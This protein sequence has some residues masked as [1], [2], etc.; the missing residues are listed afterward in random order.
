ML[1]NTQPI[2]QLITSE[3]A[4]FTI[5]D[6]AIAELREKYM[7]LTIN[8]IDDKAGY[9]K[10]KA[11]RL[12]V[13]AKRIELEKKRKEIL[14]GALTYQR[15]VNKRA[16]EI[17]EPLEAI[18]GY[19]TDMEVKFDREVAWI[20][21][22]TARRERERVQNRVAALTHLEAKF[23]G[24]CYQIK[25]T[26]DNFFFECDQVWVTTSDD[27]TFDAEIKKITAAFHVE[28]KRRNR[29][30][31]EIAMSEARL[32]ELEK[33]HQRIQQ[34]VAEAER[35]I[36]T[37]VGFADDVLRLERPAQ[38]PDEVVNIHV[39]AVN[40][41]LAPSLHTCDG[42]GFTPYK[43]SNYCCDCAVL[44]LVE[45]ENLYPRELNELT[46]IIANKTKG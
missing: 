10:V 11:A 25:Y 36:K 22:E 21:Q 20:K 6:A 29:V 15:A 5:T 41:G 4:K 8:G 24:F 19:L 46:L 3:L 33:K 14:E 30:L 26:A 28:L 18:E 12:D 34:E 7:P 16:K 43:H 40:T 2:E 17:F 42:C 45:M 37:E 44:I 9:A 23:N 13:K 1:D 38:V 27:L 32:R 35:K 31:E 39:C